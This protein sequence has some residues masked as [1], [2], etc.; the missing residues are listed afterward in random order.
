MSYRVTQEALQNALKHSH[1]ENISVHLSGGVDRLGVTVIDD[2]VG[3]VVDAT[4]GQGLGLIS[5]ADR[6]EAA[7]GTFDIRS[8]PHRGTTVEVS[9]PVAL[10][11]NAHT[12]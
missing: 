6:V 10:G 11:S 4:W 3:F 9:V 1:A 2:G 7:G 5:M 8:R 12:V